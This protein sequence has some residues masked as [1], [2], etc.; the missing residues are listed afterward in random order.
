M[1]LQPLPISQAPI[2]K[3]E[4]FGP[5]LLWPGANGAEQALG[6][7]EGAAWHT[8]DAE[9]NARLEPVA[10]MLLPSLSA[11]LTLLAI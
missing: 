2:K 7:W 1:R 10:Y 11:V 5:C 9:T 6:E 4:K 3:G 8:L